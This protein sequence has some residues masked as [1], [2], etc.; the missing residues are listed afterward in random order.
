M[1]TLTR[2]DGRTASQA[3]PLRITPGYMPH[4]EG[5]ALIEVGNTHVICAASVANSVPPW[6]KGK[7]RGWVTAEYSMLPRSTGDRTP[8]EGRDGRGAGGRT[9]EIQR[10][11]G[12]SLRAVT[13]AAAMGEMSITVDC[14]VIRA[15]AGTRAAAVT[16]GYVALSLAFRKLVESGKLKASPLTGAVAATS[17]GVVDG[18]ELLDLAYE[19]DFRAETDLNAVMTEK[20]EFVEVQGTAEAKPFDRERLGRLLDLATLGIKDLLRAQQAVLAGKS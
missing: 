13:D 11:I 5:S 8:R 18:V 12:R 15:D 7:G 9:Q 14:D 19:E 2:N 17:V 6:L 1:V 3:R 20:L 10:L 4:A 16:G